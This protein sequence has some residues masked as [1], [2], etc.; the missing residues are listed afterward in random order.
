[1]PSNLVRIRV[2][3]LL[4]LQ[5]FS[6]ALCVVVHTAIRFIIQRKVN[7]SSKHQFSICIF[8]QNGDIKRICDFSNKISELD[9]ALERVRVDS[10][11]VTQLS[12]NGSVDV[13]RLVDTLEIE[14]YRNASKEFSI[15]YVNRCILV[16]GRSSEVN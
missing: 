15:Q 12:R 14:V 5:I 3:T 8:S 1:M 9:M 11:D 4:V 13:S 2:L 10:V 16:Y 7:I 6:N